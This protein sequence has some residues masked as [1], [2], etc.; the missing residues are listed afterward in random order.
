VI[1]SIFDCDVQAIQITAKAQVAS[2]REEIATV[3]D[4]I[5]SIELEILAKRPS[6]L[7]P[8]KEANVKQIDMG[9]SGPSKTV[10]ISVHLSAK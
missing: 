4:E 6:N 5:N 2:E 7:A 9:I 1:W 3:A 10:T 8:L